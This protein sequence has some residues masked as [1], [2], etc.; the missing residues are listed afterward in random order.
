M[1]E[2]F[3]E[4]SC[5]SAESPSGSALS[6]LCERSSCCSVERPARLRGSVTS[7]FEAQRRCRAAAG[8]IAYERSGSVGAQPLSGAPVPFSL[9][10]CAVPAVALPAGLSG[11][12][13]ANWL[14]DVLPGKAGSTWEYGLLAEPLASGFE[15]ELVQVR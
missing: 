4:R 2:R 12:A 6:L 3:A 10:L 15:H 14:L 1:C 8:C 9:W 11:S 7:R 5:V 13:I